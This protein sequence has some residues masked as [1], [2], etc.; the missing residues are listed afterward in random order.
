MR[1]VPV[2]EWP[3]RLDGRGEPR[4][5]DQDSAEE[6]AQSVRV[7]LSTRPGD[8]PMR[9]A[10]GLDDPTF[11]PSDLAAS[12]LQRVASRWEPRADVDVVR[13]VAADVVRARVEVNG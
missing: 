2:P 7:L 10:Y 1:R 12:G 8:R 3:M 5:L 6:I 4:T 13:D 11:Q 9:S